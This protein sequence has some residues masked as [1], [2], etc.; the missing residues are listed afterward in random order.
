[1]ND[2]YGLRTGEVTTSGQSMTQRKIAAVFMRGG[3][4]KGVMFH[5]RDLPR[6]ETEWD[7][8]FM[9]IMGTPDPNGRQLDG[10]GGG[11]S[12]TSKICII[13][14]PTH[15]D[16]DVDYTFAQVGVHHAIVDYAGN[17]GN[18]SAAV[19]PFALDEGLL[20]K[21]KGPDTT[22]RIHNTNTGK[23][24]ISRFHNQN[25]VSQVA[26]DAV[27]DGVAGSGSPV[28]LEFTDPGGAKTGRLLPGGQPKQQLQI[29]N[30]HIVEA[31]LIDAANPCVFVTA[32]TLG[33]NG[34]E[35]P[36]EIDT[37]PELMNKLEAIRTTA[38]VA[39]GIAPTLEA[40]SA[41]S[42]VPKVALIA[43]PA[44]FRTL[45]GRPVSAD[46]MD[47]SVRMI[48]VGQAHRAVPL[49]GAMCLAA[50]ARI[51]GSLPYAAARQ[52]AKVPLRIAHASGITP[53]DAEL[54]GEGA[55]G[56]DLRVDY[57]AV[58]RTTRRLF[59]GYVRCL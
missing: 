4:S 32:S 31:S 6:D 17:C 5:R 22:V 34:S 59:E 46:E 24:I 54:S 23:I 2:G 13:G 10:M 48:S 45:A 9:R 37:R 18:M 11:I 7:P 52:T 55:C 29:A 20:A 19:G 12:S 53:V 36:Q 16:A 47:V 15:P 39:M 56:S 35:S 3:T 41:V 44:A 27:L 49:T 30:G 43:P 42:S 21:P 8:L 40:A 57:I 51:R 38:S 26:G 25:G 28:R 58:T 33:C 50:G 14:P 1:M